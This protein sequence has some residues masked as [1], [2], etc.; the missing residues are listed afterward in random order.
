M[1]NRADLQD[2]FVGAAKAARKGVV[3]YTLPREPV[4]SRTNLTRRGVFDGDRCIGLHDI[5]A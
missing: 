3:Y 2:S 1:G 4:R 5:A